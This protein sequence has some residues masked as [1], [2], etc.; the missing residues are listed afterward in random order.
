MEPINL[1]SSL[2]RK[3]TAQ[4]FSSNAQIR[5]DCVSESTLSSG[6]SISIS[7]KWNINKTLTWRLGDLSNLVA[8]SRLS[9]NVARCTRV[10]AVSHARSLAASFGSSRNRCCRTLR[11]GISCG[12]SATWEY[13]AFCQ[14]SHLN[15]Q[16]LLIGDWSTDTEVYYKWLTIW[17]NKLILMR[18]KKCKLCTIYV[19]FNISK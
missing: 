7:A 6:F 3:R 14:M 15:R 8:S 11:K 2:T 1:L 17:C 16:Q 19:T 10:S 18:Y 12:V 13:A 9:S 5:R 4:S